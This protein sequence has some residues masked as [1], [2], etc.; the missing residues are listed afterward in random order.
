MVT[1]IEFASAVKI[2]FKV[3]KDFF[4]RGNWTL[5]W[6]LRRLRNLTLGHTLQKIKLGRGPDRRH[7]WW[8]RSNPGHNLPRSNS[9][10][11]RNSSSKTTDFF[12]SSRL[13]VNGTS[14]SPGSTQV[15]AVSSH[16]AWNSVFSEIAIWDP[17]KF[18][19]CSSKCRRLWSSSTKI[20][21][22]YN[23]QSCDLPSHAR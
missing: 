17:A 9:G 10:V 18:E 16:R 23:G 4:Y 22:F 19:L 11:W 8:S 5:R 2:H 1:V 20:V 7:V 12:W 15:P 6:R 14:S 13:S 21:F 3:I